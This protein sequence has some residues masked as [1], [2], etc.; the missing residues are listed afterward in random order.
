MSGFGSVLRQRRSEL[1]LTQE[2]IANLLGVSQPA[3]ARWEMG[4]S[5][6]RG[7][8]ALRL[9]RLLRIDYDEVLG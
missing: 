2:H 7:Y 4:K 1:G 6:P 8:H 3:V 5:V 9:C